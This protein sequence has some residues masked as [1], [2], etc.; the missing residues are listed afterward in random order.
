MNIDFGRILTA[1][2]TPFNKD[3]SVNFDL[4]GKL[5]RH[6]VKSGSDGLVIAG[7]TGESPRLQRGKG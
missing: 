7:T 5:A 3:L 2:V 6:L 4:A 1:M